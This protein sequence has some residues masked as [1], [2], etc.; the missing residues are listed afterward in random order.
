MDASV[1]DRYLETKVTTAP[2]QRLRLMLIEEALRQARLALTEGEA[3]VTA[4][5]AGA[6]VRCRD[7]VAELI[8]SI[9]PDATA[10]AKQV[11]GVYLFLYSALTEARVSLDC[12]RLADVVRVLDEERVTWQEVCQRFPEP[13]AADVGAP[14]PVEEIAPQRVAATRLGTYSPAIDPA[15]TA[16]SIEA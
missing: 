7:V 14:G 8:G 9:Q 4:S 15:P 16:F 5:A 3:G 2:P 13:I 12:G 1:R 11:L 6:V 10:V